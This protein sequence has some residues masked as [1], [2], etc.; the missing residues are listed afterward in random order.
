MKSATSFSCPLRPGMGNKSRS[1]FSAL[2]MNG[3]DMI[4]GLKSG[5][6]CKAAI[7]DRGC[8]LRQTAL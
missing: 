1:R 8:C 5:R 6:L 4:Q 7:N 3:S 2:A